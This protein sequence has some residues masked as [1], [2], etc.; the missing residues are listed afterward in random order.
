MALKVSVIIPVI[1]PERAKDCIQ[2][3]LENSGIP[4]EEFEIIAEE[5]TER[6]GCPKMVKR[7]VEKSNAP[8][9]CFI[10]DDTIP[11]ENFLRNALEAMKKLPNGWGLVSL[12]DGFRIPL[13]EEGKVAAHWLADKRLLPLLD[14]EFFNTGYYHCWCDNELAERCSEMNR[15][16][17][18]ENA[19][20]IH[21]HPAI[22]KK[23]WDEHYDRV[24]APDI[25]I[26]DM[27][28]FRKR[29]R[30]KWKDE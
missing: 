1:R 23:W 30:M 15:Y 20:I 22:D 8:T 6:I 18:A 26:F 11:K 13:L 27:L 12:N 29:K 19:E 3:V 28:R 16:I 24:Y 7:L 14:G 21:N 17:Y 4:K 5:D 25:N 9:V 10:G 2:S